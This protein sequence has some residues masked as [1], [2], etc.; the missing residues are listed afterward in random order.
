MKML[1]NCA[2]CQLCLRVEQVDCHYLNVV[3]QTSSEW[4]IV[5]YI[6]ASIYMLGCAF[7]A[8][9]ASGNRQPWAQPKEE[10]DPKTVNTVTT[11]DTVN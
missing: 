3:L 11:L 9:T 8:L 7:Y 4:H 6:S 10:S 1:T 2:F 5:F